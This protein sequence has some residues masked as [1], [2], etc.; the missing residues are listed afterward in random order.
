MNFSKHD[1]VTIND[2]LADALKLVGD[3]DMKFNSRGW[4]TSQIQQCLESLSYDTF[5]LDVEKDL[6]LPESLRLEMPQGAFNLQQV[7][8]YNG[9]T[10]HIQNRVNVYHKKNFINDRSGENYVARDNYSN[11]RDRFHKQRSMISNTPDNVFFYNIQ[12][13]MIMFSPN[14][15]GFQK[16]KLVY[17]GVHTQIGEVPIIP[18]YLRQAVKSKVVV[19]GIKSRMA[20]SIGTPEYNQL[21]NLLNV[22]ENQLSHPYDGEWVKAERRVK[23]ID[24]KQKQDIK[25]Y[26]QAMNY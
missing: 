16:V 1:F 15:Y 13:G 21:F 17:N 5:F 20:Q 2:I 9:D 11:Y 6:E 26:F 12:N 23:S 8:L 24:R 25:E 14:C 4:Y 3:V 18:T 19:E 22:H 10:C 7:Y